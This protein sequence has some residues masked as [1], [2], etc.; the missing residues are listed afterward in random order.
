MGIYDYSATEPETTAHGAT[1]ANRI[2]R[3]ALSVSERDLDDQVA[4]LLDANTGI[5]AVVID[6]TGHVKLS[7]SPRCPGEPGFTLAPAVYPLIQSAIDAAADG[8]AVFVG[9]GTYREQLTIRGKHVDL[10]GATGDDG[11]PLAVVEA[12]DIAELDIEPVE[13]AGQ[14]AGQC[15]IVRVRSDAHVTVRNLVIDGRHQG[16][17]FNRS[18]PDVQFKSITTDNAYTIVDHVE[19]RGFEATEAVRLLDESG[20]LRATYPTLREAISSAAAGDEVVLAPGMYAEDLYIDQQITISRADD[21][22]SARLLGVKALIIGRVVVAA[23]AVNV[24]LDGVTIEGSLQTES[25]AGAT[26]SITLRNSRIEGDHTI[27]EICSRVAG[28]DLP[29]LAAALNYR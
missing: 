15:S 24:A 1:A 2:E 6:K 20:H 3:Y 9:A 16:W 23:S 26:A 22:V 12:P 19:T 13:S 29:D 28:S 7:T 4:A 5:G 10:L 18:K 14:L 8:D 25:V 21:R 27:T 17:M 11:S